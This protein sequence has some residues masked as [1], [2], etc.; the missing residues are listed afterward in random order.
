MK[1]RRTAGGWLLIVMALGPSLTAA[2]ALP[3]RPWLLVRFEGVESVRPG[4][5]ETGLGRML[6]DPD[7]A[8]S[9][10]SLGETIRGRIG[11]PETI[12]TLKAFL[13]A[14]WAVGIYPPLEGSGS[15]ELVLSA[16]V[17]DRA[18]LFRGRLRDALAAEMGEDGVENRTIG[19][20]KIEAFHVVGREGAD[21]FAAAGDRLV[22][23]SNPDLLVEALSSDRLDPRIGETFAGLETGRPVAEVF[24][25]VSE[26]VSYLRAAQPK[27]ARIAGAFSLDELDRF[28]VKIGFDGSRIR[29]AGMLRFRGTEDGEGRLRG[30]F[31]E[32]PITDDDLRRVPAG[33]AAFSVVRFDLKPWWDYVMNG[34]VAARPETVL[35]IAAASTRLFEATGVDLQRDLVEAL[36]DTGFFYASPA[37]TAGAG[38][39]FPSSFAGSTAAWTLRDEDAFRTSLGRLLAHLS[40]VWAKRGA[41]NPRTAAWRIERSGD[42]DAEIWSLAGAG[43][44]VPSVGVGGGRVVVSLHPEVCRA[45][46]ARDPR[47]DGS[48]LD[49]EAFAA[50]WAALKDRGVTWLQWEDL[51]R[52]LPGI[53]GS[54]LV[55]A[56]VIAAAAGGTMDPS[57][58]PRP[59]SLT[60]Y[61][62]P[63]FAWRWTEGDAVRFEWESPVGFLGAGNPMDPTVSSLGAAIAWPVL[64]RARDRARRSASQAKL[65]A[66][67][68]AL[69]SYGADHGGRYPARLKDLVPKYLPDPGI[70]ETPWGGSYLYLCPGIRPAKVEN[71]SVIPVVIR[72]GRGSRRGRSVLFLDGAVRWVPESDVL[73]LMMRGSRAATESQPSERPADR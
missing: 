9:I 33:A 6:N 50:R 10:R 57:N 67:G 4:F 43:W 69:E 72:D 18:E 68:A 20:G 28:V 3:G 48:I 27:I 13:S 23:A 26:I 73:D 21:W 55:A 16:E 31:E 19:D 42:G 35:R 46:L 32:R 7:I 34:L 63:A 15:A 45:E 56:P 71:P 1:R 62:E 49:D 2:P 66:V 17:G 30:L 36:G 54:L 70:L 29:G 38:G 8:P 22:S 44:F 37:S 25:D 52:T 51:G 47:S 61:L 14:P 60:P 59:E 40:E 65:A 11:D 39:L 41:G 53:Y 58:L 5:A 12:D 24:L 64:A